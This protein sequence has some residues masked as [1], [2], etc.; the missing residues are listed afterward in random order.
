MKSMLK[1]LKFNTIFW[2]IFLSI[3]A[4]MLLI[5]MATTFTVSVLLDRDHLNVRRELMDKYQADIAVTLFESKGRVA[6]EEWMRERHGR[7]AR[8]TFLIDGRGKDV[9]GRPLPSQ[10]SSRLTEPGRFEF[11]MGHH[12]GVAQPVSSSS[13]EQY[14]FVRLL[15]VSRPQ[16]RSNF[17]HL[18]PPHLRGVVFLV[19]L[20]VTGL[21]SYWLAQNITWPIRQLQTA[22]RKISGGDLSARVS[23]GVA[24]RRDELGDLGRE[25]DRMAEHIEEL[26]SAQKRMLRDVS[27]E[28][29]SPLARLQVAL[30]LARKSVGEQGKVG[31]DRIEREANRLDE[32][33]E[34]VLSLVRLTTNG[35]DIEM[36]QLDVCGIVEQVVADAN[37]EAESQQKQV[38]LIAAIPF[39][40]SGNA[41]LL[42]SALENIVR[43]AV[44]YSPA[45]TAVEVNMSI[46][47]GGELR[48]CVRDYGPGVSEQRLAHIFEPFYRE[49]EARDRASGGYGLGLA[50]AQSSIRLHGGDICAGNADRGG[51]MMEI[52]L[53]RGK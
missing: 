34:Q 8:F 7:H 27:H 19:A 26:L 12:R 6:L 53:P 50:I 38:R 51:L 25:F 20:L 46:G 44:K 11:G 14:W 30:E 43:N 45:N 31:H 49:A 15:P 23:G 17:W 9:L 42:H 32:L 37:Y 40:M 22:T 5:M 39:P 2:K 1:R 48:I 35:A 36:A 10:I 4:A 3:W 21:I 13:G 47:Q 16:Y 28:L 33:I 29:R 18:G 52:V 24:Q 41:G